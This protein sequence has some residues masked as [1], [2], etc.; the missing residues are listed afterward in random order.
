MEKKAFNSTL[1]CVWSINRF[2]NIVWNYLKLIVAL[3]DDNISNGQKKKMSPQPIT[4]SRTLQLSEFGRWRTVQCLHNIHCVRLRQKINKNT[5]KNRV[6]VLISAFC[7]VLQWCL[8]HLSLQS[9]VLI[10]M[11]FCYWCCCC[12]CCS[13]WKL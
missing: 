4:I 2:L 11:Y 3:F 10:Q 1:Y 5:S 8:C 13:C 12:F 6:K 9:G 7:I